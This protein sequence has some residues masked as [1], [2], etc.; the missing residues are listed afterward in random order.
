[1]QPTVHIF[2][3]PGTDVVYN[4]PLYLV[5]PDVLCTVGET[6]SGI[7]AGFIE[8]DIVCN[9]ILFIYL[10]VSEMQSLFLSSLSNKNHIL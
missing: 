7:W 1:M 10:F 8:S 5:C 3:T 4:H 6:S 9:I 2:H